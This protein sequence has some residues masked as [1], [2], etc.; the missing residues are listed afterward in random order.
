MYKL[1]IVEDEHLIRKWL[2]YAIDYKSLGILVVGEAKDG[3]EGAALIKETHPDIVL[4]DINMP[5]MTAFE[6]FDATQDYSYAKIIL[7]GYADF[8]NARSALHYGVL[9]FLTKPLE[10]EVLYDCL[11]TIMA[12]LDQQR[13]RGINDYSYLYLKLP[14]ITEQLPETAQEMLRFI[15]EHYHE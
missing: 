13:N 5:I 7:S 6:M 2:H 15:H 14:Q 10:K 12:R 8:P 1:V 4:T 11:K 9:E 3:K